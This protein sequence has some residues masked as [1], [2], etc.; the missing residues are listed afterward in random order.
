MSGV[1]V[2]RKYVVAKADRAIIPD[3]A[4]K[5]IDNVLESLELS[6]SVRLEKVKKTK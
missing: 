4:V 1:K 5:I 3:L 6:A 2:I